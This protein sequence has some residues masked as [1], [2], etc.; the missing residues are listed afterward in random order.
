MPAINRFFTCVLL[1]CRRRGRDK[2][3]SMLAAATMRYAPTS[4]GEKTSNPLLIRIKELPQI[5]VST[6][7]RIQFLREFSEVLVSIRG[8]LNAKKLIF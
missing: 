1:S 5:K 8:G 7:K 6:T 3:S 4:P 2:G